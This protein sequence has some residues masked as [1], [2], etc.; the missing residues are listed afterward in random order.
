MN[1]RECWDLNPGQLG[2]EARTLSTV[3]CGQPP[4]LVI[5]FGNK[6]R[7]HLSRKMQY[8]ENSIYNTLK[9]FHRKIRC[10]VNQTI[11]LNIEIEFDE[12]FTQHRMQILN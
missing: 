1:Y 3:L 8:V 2:S 5:L 12:L 6:G 9:T 11:Q 7:I 10:I 4:L